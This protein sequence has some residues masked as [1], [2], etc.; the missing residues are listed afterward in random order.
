MTDWLRTSVS[1]LVLSVRSDPDCDGQSA[2]DRGHATLRAA[3]SS[4]VSLIMTVKRRLSY[5]LVSVTHIVSG[6]VAL[7]VETLKLTMTWGQSQT[8]VALGEGF[9]CGAVFLA[10]GAVAA[11]Q[12]K[13]TK[14]ERDTMDKVYY[15][16]SIINAVFA[17]WLVL[18]SG[19]VF[20]GSLVHFKHLPAI[21]LHLIMF[22]TA[23]TDLVFTIISCSYSC[24]RHCFCCYLCCCTSS[25]QRSDLAKATFSEEDKTEIVLGKQETVLTV[26]QNLDQARGYS[27]FV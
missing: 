14:Q 21:L 1:R 20:V 22:L 12:H 15:T 16:F 2:S 9:Y 18:T 27:R 6:L 3:L 17:G 25:S 13:Y 8:M 19:S 4:V 10:A 23:T 11:L 7:L 24:H 5:S 26:Q